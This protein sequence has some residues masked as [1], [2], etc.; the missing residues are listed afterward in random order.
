MS[1]MEIEKA[2][3]RM[4]SVM[5]NHSRDLSGSWAK[6][7]DACDAIIDHISEFEQ[8]EKQLEDGWREAEKRC[9]VDVSQLNCE[10]RKLRDEIDSLK[11]QIPPKYDSERQY[12][13]DE[14]NKVLQYACDVM[15]PF[16]GPNYEVIHDDR[17]GALRLQV[18]DIYGHIGNIKYH[19]PPTPPPAK[20]RIVMVRWFWQ[21]EFKIIYVKSCGKFDFVGRLIC[22]S[23]IHVVCA[24][25]DINWDYWCD[26]LDRSHHSP[27]WKREWEPDFE[28]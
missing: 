21:H 10:N 18:I 5:S 4:R 1:D 11:K 6:D 16:V 24:N 9:E 28:K 13:K 27:S 12:T 8:R 2:L 25:D 23:G 26:Y 19:E 17:N 20:D 14:L 3:Q 15:E 22:D 7:C